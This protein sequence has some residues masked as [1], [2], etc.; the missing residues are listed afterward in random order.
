MAVP[1]DHD[2]PVPRDHDWPV[3]RDHDWPVPRDHDWPVPR[4]HDWPVPRDH[5]W[6]VPRDHDWP[7]PR[8]HDWPGS[9]PPAAMSAA[10][11]STA[12]DSSARSVTWSAKNI[13]PT[14]TL[15]IAMAARSRSPSGAA[16]PASSSMSEL[17]RSRNSSP[18]FLAAARLATAAWFWCSIRNTSSPST[19]MPT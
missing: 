18:R 16:D 7:V 12:A 9:P 14:L 5:D 1:R 17:I 2:W 15:P 13:Q 19:T 4:D 6:P 8:D 11:A 10:M 3:P